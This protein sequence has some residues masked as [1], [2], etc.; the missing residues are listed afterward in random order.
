MR[1]TADTIALGVAL[2][3]SLYLLGPS[4]A[5]PFAIAAAITSAAGLAIAMRWLRI[6]LP[7]VDLAIAA[8]LAV[9]GVILVLRVD[10]KLRVVAAA[11]LTTIAA[12]ALLAVLF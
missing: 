11:A 4:R 1:L 9:L 3:A 8:I 2:A 12:L 10:E 7:H 5:R 6:P